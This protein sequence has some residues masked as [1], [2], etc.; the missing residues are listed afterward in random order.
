[1]ELMHNIF[2]R[3]TV[4]TRLPHKHF[5]LLSVKL[6]ERKKKQQQLDS[7]KHRNLPSKRFQKKANQKSLFRSSC[8]TMIII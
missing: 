4:K 5:L 1:M 8:C 2:K 7:P 3:C 6:V